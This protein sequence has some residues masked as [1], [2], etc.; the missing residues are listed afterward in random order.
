MNHSSSSSA[1]PDVSIIDDLENAKKKAHVNISTAAPKEYAKHTKLLNTLTA[2][3]KQSRSV[4]SDAVDLHDRCPT[5]IPQSREIHSYRLACNIHIVLFNYITTRDVKPLPN[6]GVYGAAPMTPCVA[7]PGTPTPSFSLPKSSPTKS[8]STSPL[9]SLAGSSLDT[10]TG[11]SADEDLAEEVGSDKKTEEATRWAAAMAALNGDDN[12][13]DGGDG[14]GEPADKKE[15]EAEKVA[16]LDPTGPQ[17]FAKAPPAPQTPAALRPLMETVDFDMEVD[18]WFDEDIILEGEKCEQITKR[19]V[20]V[21]KKLPPRYRI[22]KEYQKVHC[23]EQIKYIVSELSDCET[24]A[25][26]EG[27]L[28][29]LD[30]ARSVIFTWLT[31]LKECAKE[32][33]KSVTNLKN[34]KERE[35]QKAVQMSVAK[36][37]AAIREQAKLAAAQVT[38]I[39]AALAPIFTFPQGTTLQQCPEFIQGGEFDIN[40]P[41]LFKKVP[42]HEEYA[43]LPKVQLMLGNFGGTYK[44][45]QQYK[46]SGF[47]Q[48]PIYKDF[49][50]HTCMYVYVCV[51]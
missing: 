23:L 44:K 3:M 30:N 48:S 28:A 15:A 37:S 22:T 38:A 17:A 49:C 33:K 35:A 45:S 21:L 5:D 42:G 24:L 9:A 13:V 19:L 1:G 14:S 51:C 2:S 50:E 47:Y 25:E 20:E 26:L 31:A 29:I 36:D 34:A 8:M 27:K 16:S 11:A 6:T 40:A 43:K 4:L 7:S 10:L 32:L 39:E 18:S 41:L 46:D 12:K